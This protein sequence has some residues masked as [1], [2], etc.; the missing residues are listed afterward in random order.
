MQTIKKVRSYEF[1]VRSNQ[2]RAGVNQVTIMVKAKLYT[3]QI[4]SAEFGGKGER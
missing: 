4:G 3:L 1:G 2:V